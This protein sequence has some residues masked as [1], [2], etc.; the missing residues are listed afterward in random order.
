MFLIVKRIHEYVTSLFWKHHTASFLQ[1]WSRPT[2]KG[3]WWEHFSYHFLGV[4]SEIKLF[5]GMNIFTYL[6]RSNITQIHFHFQ[7]CQSPDWIML[8]CHTFSIVTFSTP[9]QAGGGGALQA[10]ISFWG[11]LSK[12]VNIIDSINQATAAYLDPPPILLL[13]VI[14]ASSSNRIADAPKIAN[15][16]KYPGWPSKTESK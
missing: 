2:S 9:G 10:V 15:P 13:I 8:P 1:I 16:V 6:S 4:E 14:Y 5:Q 3:L 7:G 11:L 12:L